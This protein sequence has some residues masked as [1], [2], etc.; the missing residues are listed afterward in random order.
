MPRHNS[1][2]PGTLRAACNFVLLF[3]A[4]N[5][6]RSGLLAQSDI[7]ARAWGDP[8]DMSSL[9]SRQASEHPIPACLFCPQ[10]KYTRKIAHAK[11]KGP[12][13]LNALITSEGRATNIRI[14]KSLGHGLDRK[15]IKTVESWL[16][17]PALGPDGKRTAVLQVIEVTFPSKPPIG[18][19]TSA[20]SR[21]QK[22]LLSVSR[23]TA[24]TSKRS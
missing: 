3:I 18:S 1:L 16:F 5:I 9:Y 15:A 24:T 22:R 6:G 17:R 7:S 12:V 13:V 2:S 21:K 11:L 4:V 14:T 23:I 20:A 8:V 19:D 10:P